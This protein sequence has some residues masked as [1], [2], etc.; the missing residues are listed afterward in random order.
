MGPPM[1]SPIE[2]AS[3]AVHW[4]L[5]EV[6]LFATTFSPCPLPPEWKHR[7]LR[8]PHDMGPLG[9]LSRRTPLTSGGLCDPPGAV[10]GASDQD[11]VMPSL[12]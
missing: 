3:R 7:I 9:N 12:S 10:L 2:C 4:R 5:P 1:S 8:S 11:A 6:A